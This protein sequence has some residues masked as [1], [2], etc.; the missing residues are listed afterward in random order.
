[1]RQVHT[2]SASTPVLI[3]DQGGT[4]ESINNDHLETEKKQFFGRGIKCILD[5][6]EEIDE[7]VAK[8]FDGKGSNAH[9]IESCHITDKDSIF[10]ETFNTSAES[11]T[12]LNE[13]NYQ[14][15]R[16]VKLTNLHHEF[17]KEDLKT[18]LEPKR[19]DFSSSDS[20]DEDVIFMKTLNLNEPLKSIAISNNSVEETTSHVSCCRT[21]I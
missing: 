1:M 9:N 18:I 5:P 20:C 8:E 12:Y 15:R 4:G 2:L 14:L 3:E 21:E 17:I 16:T 6:I 7:E 19:M 13:S 11:A 10:I